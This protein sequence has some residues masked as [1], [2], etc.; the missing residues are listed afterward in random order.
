MASGV[1][2]RRK[3]PLTW[4]NTDCQDLYD[5][6]D[7]TP[8]RCM[9]SVVAGW[10]G[11]P[12]WRGRRTLSVKIGGAGTVAHA[13][14]V[15]PRLLSDQLGLTAGL[16]AVRARA[17]FVPVRHRGGERWWTPRAPWRRERPV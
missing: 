5:S 11:I 14:V 9:V 4:D 1:S 2:G 6:E 16:S 3:V 7:G 10:L 15:L 8:F 17:G 13:G 12:R